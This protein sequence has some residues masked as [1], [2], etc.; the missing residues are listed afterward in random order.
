MRKSPNPAHMSLDEVADAIGRSPNMIKKYRMNPDAHPFFRKAF[1]TGTGQNSPL[2]WWR[3]DVEE[4][5]RE[6]SGRGIGGA[7]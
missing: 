6:I 1:K 3:A 4:Y 5:L 7:A 2:R